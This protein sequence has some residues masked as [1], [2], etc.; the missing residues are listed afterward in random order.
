MPDISDV[1]KAIWIILCFLY[2]MLFIDISIITD[3][4]T[5]LKRVKCKLGG[6]KC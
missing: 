6:K 1:Y 2:C 3:L 4:V 5:R